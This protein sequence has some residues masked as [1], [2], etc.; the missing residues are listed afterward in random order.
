MTFPRSLDNKQ[1]PELRSIV[2]TYSGQA[3][4]PD[5]SNFNA[6]AM[7]NNDLYAKCKAIC[8]IFEQ[9][10]RY[11]ELGDYYGNVEKPLPEIVFRTSLVLT[12]GY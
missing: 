12:D 4:I 6:Q 10:G 2:Q 7:A 5:S 8:R 11:Y 3:A 1:S 9:R